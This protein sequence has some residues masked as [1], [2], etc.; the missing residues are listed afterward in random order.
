MYIA[1]VPHRNAPPAVLLREAWREGSQTRQR[2]LANLSHGPQEKIETFRRLLRDE[3]WVSPQ[4][5][6]ATQ[7]TLPHGHVEAIWERIG[8]LELDRWMAAQPCHE[9]DWVVAMIVQRWLDPGSKRATT[10][11]WPSTT[12]AE[13]W[14][15][16]EASEDDLYQ[17]WTGFWHVRK[18][19]RRSWRGVIG[20][21][22]AW[23]SMTCRAVF[24]RAVAARWHNWATTAMGRTVGPSSF[25][26]G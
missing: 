6:L 5:R 24:M 17:P 10:R 21:R 13:E 22:A 3:R 11:A 4:D 23:C 25:M 8:R 18:A 26:G 16:A 15:V 19:S 14:G 9:R 1:I 20:A 2:T 7:K 12:L